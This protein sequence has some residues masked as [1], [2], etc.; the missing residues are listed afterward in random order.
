MT[1]PAP[2]LDLHPPR[3]RGG[4]LAALN[5]LLDALAVPDLLVA[6]FPICPACSTVTRHPCP[7]CAP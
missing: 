4:W 5:R 6:R 1:T 2:W 7:R 3:P